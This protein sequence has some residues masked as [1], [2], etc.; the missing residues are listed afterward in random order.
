MEISGKPRIVIW[1]VSNDGRFIGN[2]VNILMRQF[3]GVD[4]IGV[5]AAQ[6][7]SVNNLPFIPLQELAQNGGGYDVLLVA[8]ARQMGIAEVVKLAK[9]IKLDADKLLGDW[10][11][12]IPGFTLEKYRKLQRS[13]LS[14]FSFDCLGGIINHDL[15]LK[16]F[17]PFFNLQVEHYEEFLKFLKHPRVYIEEELEFQGT[18][19]RNS[20][21][22]IFDYPIYSIGN[23]TLLMVHYS[24]FDHAVKKWNERK[25]RINWY[26]II[27]MMD[28]ESQEILE[29]FD[30]L[31]YGKKVCFVPF[32]SNLDSAFYIDPKYAVNG[33]FRSVIA[34]L[35]QIVPHYY[36]VFDMLLYGKKTPLIEM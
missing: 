35:A 33:S 3:N 28:T 25:Q 2:A 29:K 15:G 12:C 34:N 22:E 13:K 26:N 6:K 20:G 1:F 19:H 4:I 11:V 10:I 7:I 27:A 5:T 16:T 17:S 31:T 21:K 32:K 9:S 36:N 8:G 18:R 30:A 14:I 23:V 24:N